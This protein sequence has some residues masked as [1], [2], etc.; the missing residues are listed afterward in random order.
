MRAIN[1]RY[2]LRARMTN[3]TE[4]TLKYVETRF[5]ELAESFKD[6]LGEFADLQQQIGVLKNYVAYAQI[7]YGIKNS[8]EYLTKIPPSFVTDLL[9]RLGV[10]AKRNFPGKK[11][12]PS[13]EVW[14]KEFQLNPFQSYKVD[15]V[16]DFLAE[17]I[18]KFESEM[19][20]G[21]ERRNAGT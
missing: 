5:S 21:E 14:E 19:A 11:I 8:T 6:E 18:S 15:V 17:G 16:F 9:D 4:D 13:K 7:F 1:I 2:D 20:L 3:R 12:S 10:W